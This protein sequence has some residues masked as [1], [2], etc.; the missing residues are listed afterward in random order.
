MKKY[1]VQSSRP[2]AHRVLV[3]RSIERKKGVLSETMLILL[4]GVTQGVTKVGLQL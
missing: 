3:L 4:V 2:V 1:L